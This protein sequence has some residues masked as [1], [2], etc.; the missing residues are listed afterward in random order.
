MR[1]ESTAACFDTARTGTEERAGEV[2]LLTIGDTVSCLVVTHQTIFYRLRGDGWQI[3]AP[4]MPALFSERNGFKKPHRLCFGWRL[5][6]LRAED[7]VELLVRVD[8]AERIEQ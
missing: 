6:R 1:G 2:R 7:L 3:K 4:W 5:F 8:R